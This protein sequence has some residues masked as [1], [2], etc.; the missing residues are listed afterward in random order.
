MGALT[1][2]VEIPEAILETICEILV[3]SAKRYGSLPAVKA[4]GS[5]SWSYAQLAD[6]SSRVAGYLVGQGIAKGDRVIFWGANCP[7]WVAAYFG[8]QIV[9]AVG[10]PIDLRSR[11]D[12]V[13]RV[14]EQT[15]PV[16]YFL[17]TEQL[18]ALSAPPNSYTLIDDLVAITKSAAPF[19]LEDSP[20]HPDDVAEL[21]FTSGTTGAP[22]G[23]MLTN[24]NIVS[25]VD[26]ARNALETTPDIRLLSL[27]PLSHM[28]EQT[29]GLMTP[30]S[31]GSSITY[32]RSLRPDVIFKAM[33]E[34]RVTHMLCVPQVLQLFRSG[35]ERELS[36]QGRER[37]FSL[38]HRIARYLPL[39]ARRK[40]FGAIHE[41]FGG[42][43]ECFL[44]GGAYL[45]PALSR[46]WEQ[47]GVKVVQ[48][49]G[50]TEG[51][52][53]VTANT[54]NDR[55]PESIG[56]PLPGVE[57]KISEAGEI[58]VR[59][60][61]I[62]LGYWQNPEATAESFE[63]DWYRTGD[64]GTI[65]KSGRVHLKGRL[66]NMIVLSNGM[67]VHPEDIEPLLVR[68]PAV[69]EAV[70]LG[71]GPDHDPEVHAV[72]KLSDESANLD[73]ILRAANADLAPHQRIRGVTIWPDDEFPITHTLKIKRMD[74][75]TRVEE[76]RAGV[77][78][79]PSAR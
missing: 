57:L 54:P 35:I 37:Q 4:A 60:P 77:P 43:F 33:S 34:E 29:I 64:L 71:M 31:G 41:R 1:V 25:N 68:D 65:D 19:P 7:E 66:K 46:W 21:V 73:E 10:I 49:Y 28:F 14:A 36:R 76:L 75:K 55:D 63:G 23:V 15:Q 12:L 62:T 9:G 74:V 16:H 27:L 47:L 56:R 5:E 59:G 45:D 70:V 40:I 48:G 24:R 26:M 11:E 79:G 2:I 17:G 8:A 13:L 6:I 22:K 42:A 53:L 61:N 69:A 67:K 3:Q 20:V 72:V 78:V 32:I 44:V 18:K 50:M 30:L 58:L 39:A 52:P 51:S 38:S